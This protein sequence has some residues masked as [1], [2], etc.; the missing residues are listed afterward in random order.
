MMEKVG[1]AVTIVNDLK[2]Y[3]LP[4]PGCR[5]LALCQAARDASLLG[6]V[7][8]T[9]AKAASHNAAGW[10]SS[11][12]PESEEDLETAGQLGSEGRDC[13]QIYE[14]QSGNGRKGFFPYMYNFVI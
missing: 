10:L 6:K 3:F 7:G 8:R 4:D 2:M 14:C 9:V 5:S 12:Y 11:K 13:I 1:T